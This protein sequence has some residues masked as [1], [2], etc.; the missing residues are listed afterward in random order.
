MVVKHGIIESD[1]WNFDETG[2]LMGQITSTL[3]IT[4]SDGRV[5]AKKIQPGNREWVTV[6]QAVRSDGEIISLYLIVAGKIHLESWYR[7]S[8]F[9]P[10]WTI[11]LSETGWTN[12]QI[13]IH[14]IKHFD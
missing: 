1:I 3:V 6:I 12:N 10:E 9:P 2:F 4:S 13:N 8:P 5:K 7:N 14:W 11:D